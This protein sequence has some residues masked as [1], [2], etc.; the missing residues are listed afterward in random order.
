MELL[1]VIYTNDRVATKMT[2]SAKISPIYE[3]GLPSF[4]DFFLRSG[5]QPLDLKSVHFCYFRS[6]IGASPDYPN[7]RG[8]GQL[9][10]EW[11]I[12]L[13][14]I[15]LRVSTEQ[16]WLEWGRGRK[17]LKSRRPTSVDSK[18]LR[19]FFMGNFGRFKKW[20]TSGENRR[21]ILV[22]SCIYFLKSLSTDPYD[23]ATASE[24]LALILAV[25]SPSTMN[26]C[27]HEWRLPIGQLANDRAADPSV[28]LGTK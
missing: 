19:P 18:F 21:S 9:Q 8:E 1:K 17:I 12:R 2:H 22:H 16:K 3:I 28:A 4:W 7:W 10:H 20:N 14:A 11:S 24:T 5:L 23:Y 27:R 6:Y 25:I 26:D 15:I 13:A